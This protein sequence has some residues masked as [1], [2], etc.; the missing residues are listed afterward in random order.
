MDHISD[1]NNSM[2]YK[3][4]KSVEL[5]EFVADHEQMTEK[6]AS[7]LSRDCFADRVKKQ[8]P[9]HTEADTWLSVAYY[10]KY[11]SAR[12]TEIEEKLKKAVSF[13]GIEDSMVN[14]KNEL[15]GDI[16]KKATDYTNSRIA[17][18]YVYD[19]EAKSS[20]S[21]G[22][23][24]ELQKVAT[25]LVKNAT[26]YPYE[27]RKS[28]SRQVISAEKRLEGALTKESKDILYK[29][30]GYATSNK[31]NI[32]DVLN[33]KKYEHGEHSKLA[34]KL[35]DAYVLIEKVA[36]D[37]EFV[38]PVLIDKVA[39][40]LDKIDRFVGLHHRYDYTPPER[41]LYNTTLNDVNNFN[42]ENVVLHGNTVISKQ[43][44]EK[45]ANEVQELYNDVFNIKAV[46]FQDVLDNLDKLSEKEASFL[47]KIVKEG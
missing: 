44:L 23:I 33:T 34:S 18:S 19:G 29:T 16:E 12:D 38:E 14:L 7:S 22:D 46:S 41:V 15:V 11:A 30:A 5:P 28:V 37:V 10:S 25:D 24:D 27:M 20:T 21:V 26:K 31:E 43:A 45:K 47:S 8:Y 17:I 9:I 40:M 3:L 36:G 42:S 1:K 13:W 35:D 32:L 2:L 4:A 39:S 6:E